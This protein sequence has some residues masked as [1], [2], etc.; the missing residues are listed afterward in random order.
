VTLALILLFFHA[1]EAPHDAKMILFLE[2][3]VLHGRKCLREFAAWCLQTHSACFCCV[4]QLSFIPSGHVDTAP[5][6]SFWRV[7]AG[8][9]QKQPNSMRSGPGERNRKACEGGAQVP[10]LRVNARTSESMQACAGTEEKQQHAKQNHSLTPMHP[11]SKSVQYTR[12]SMHCMRTR[13]NQTHTLT[14]NA[15]GTIHAGTSISPT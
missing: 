7:A 11:G 8:A 13:G 5:A 10:H 9:M 1:F 4:P 14:P 3:H 6:V 2:R 12:A 15:W